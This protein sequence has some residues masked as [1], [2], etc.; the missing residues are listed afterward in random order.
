MDIKHVNHKV[1]ME[2]YMNK[3]KL[4]EYYDWMDKQ[5]T[6]DCHSLHIYT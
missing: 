5:D 1:N 2:D 3:L 4:K 6:S